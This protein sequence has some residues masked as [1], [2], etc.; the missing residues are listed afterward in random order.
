MHEYETT[1]PNKWL[2]IRDKVVA[3]GGKKYDPAL[4]S[5][6]YNKLPKADKENAGLRTGGRAVNEDDDEGSINSDIDHI[7]EEGK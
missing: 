5:R 7:K 2:I 4:L 1:K 3:A 6:E